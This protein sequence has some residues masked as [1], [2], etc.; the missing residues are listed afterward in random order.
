MSCFVVPAPVDSSSLITFLDFLQG[1]EKHALGFLPYQA[2]RQAIELDRVLLCYENDEPAGY[3]IH[4]PPKA[5]SKIYQVVVC[6]DVRRI[7]HGTALIEAVKLRANRAQGEILSLHC[8]EDLDA[9]AFWKALGF[10]FTGTRCRRKD[11]RR[12]QNRYEIELPGKKIAADRRIAELNGIRER[13][14]RD[15]LGRLRSLLCKNDK[16]HENVTFSRKKGR[17]HQIVIPE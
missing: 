11:G 13:V 7:E 17:K 16:G 1:R 9:N 2:L 10:E 4:G 15:G 5:E 12:L 14:K 6:D 8:A 3:T